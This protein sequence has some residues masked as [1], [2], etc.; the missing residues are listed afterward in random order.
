[1]HHKLICMRIPHT[2]LQA[3]TTPPPP[4][5]A[6]PANFP[7][8]TYLI[9]ISKLFSLRQKPMGTGTHLCWGACNVC[10]RHHI[11]SHVRVL[12]FSLSPIHVHIHINTRVYI[13]EIGSHLRLNNIIIAPKQM[14]PVEHLNQTHFRIY[15]YLSSARRFVSYLY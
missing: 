1:M 2:I 6:S 9:N 11:I 3:S 10:G 13:F 7:Y 4:P 15:V 12:R 8:F 14:F 5:F